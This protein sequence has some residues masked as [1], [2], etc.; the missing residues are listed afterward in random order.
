M[1]I[2]SIIISL[3][4]QAIY[5]N[6]LLAFLFLSSKWKIAIKRKLFFSFPRTMERVNQ[7]LLPYVK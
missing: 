6:Q 1:N 3:Y 4:C 7:C 5:P 2:T